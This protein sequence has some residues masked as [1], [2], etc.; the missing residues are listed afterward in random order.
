M[1]F[2]VVSLESRRHALIRLY[3]RFEW[4]YFQLKGR[5]I[6]GKKARV[7]G[8]FRV[9]GFWNIEIGAN[10]NINSGVFMLGF[11]KIKIG[12]NVTLSAGCMLID[13]GLT[14]GVF[15]ADADRS[16]EGAPIIL[17]DDVWI[18]AGAIV[19]AGVTVGRGSVVGAGSVVTKSIPPGNIVAGVPAKVI[20]IRDARTPIQDR[21]H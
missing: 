15:G 18:G 2:I 1:G 4:M 16:H 11:S 20:G 13:G 14:R 19:L 21:E 8:N 17:E 5:M 10:V 6:L 3:R 12:D 7:H 9:E